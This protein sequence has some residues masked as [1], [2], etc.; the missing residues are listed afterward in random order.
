MFQNQRKTPQKELTV[1][2]KFAL[3]R[4]T[5]GNKKGNN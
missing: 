2:I 4:K 5:T 3:A 1:I